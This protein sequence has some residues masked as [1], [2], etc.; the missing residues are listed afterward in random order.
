ME[1]DALSAFVLLQDAFDLATVS[2]VPLKKKK[3]KMVEDDRLDGKAVSIVPFPP[4]PPKKKGGGGGGG[5]DAFIALIFQ[6]MIRLIYQVW[7]FH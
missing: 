6:C 5:E 7:M 2:I 4:P 1:D 3:K